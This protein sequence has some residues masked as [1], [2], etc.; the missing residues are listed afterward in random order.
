MKQNRKTLVTKLAALL[1]MILSISIYAQDPSESLI[2]VSKITTWVSDKGFH[3]WIVNGAWNG[4]YPNGS[5]EGVIFSEGIVWGGLV[6]DGQSQ[7]VRVDGN[8][9]GSGCSANTRLY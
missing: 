1:L 9:Y 4:A 6:N 7:V 3:D 2:N 5:S 8:T